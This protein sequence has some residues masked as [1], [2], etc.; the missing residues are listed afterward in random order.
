MKNL[1]ILVDMDD[2]IENLSEAWIAFLNNR[3]GTSV[4]PK[5]ITEWDMQKAFPTLQGK[6][7]YGALKEKALWEMVKPLPGAVKYLKKLIDDGN[8]VF[9]VTA[10]H[11]DTVSAK[12]NTVLF[13]YFP[14]IPHENVIITSSKQLIMGDFLVDDAPHNMGGQYKGLLFTANHNRAVSDDELLNVNA[15][16]VDN[17]KE[18]YGLIHGYQVHNEEIT[19]GE[20]ND[21]TRMARRRQ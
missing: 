1:T 8:Q 13:K 19:K 9:I 17:W 12:M 18:A 6:D 11:P 15:V 2:T 14:F 16:R 21:R 20:S 3:Y 10:S 5:D 7:I 4:K